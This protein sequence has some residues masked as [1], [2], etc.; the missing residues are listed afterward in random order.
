MDPTRFIESIDRQL[1]RRKVEL[2]NL[3]IMV[4]EQN[5]D[6]HRLSCIA[7]SA[8]VLAYAHWE[9]FVKRG[10]GDYVKFINGAGI[11]VADLKFP[12]QAAYVLS[13]FKRASNS[14]KTRYLG[15]L[16]QEID[17]RRAEVFSVPPDKCI[18]TESNLSSNV[19]K[20][21]V[22]GV[23]LDILPLYETRSVFIDQRIVLARNQVAHGELVSFDAVDVKDRIDGVRLLID[24]YADQLKN[25]AS[26]DA[27][28]KI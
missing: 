22:Q 20:E 23:G 6:P 14:V 19:F 17:A 27:Y 9:G 5:P 4:S 25:A 12:F 26:A 16:L 1:A 10:S 15:E 2:S 18:D 24:T 21:I 3:S 28:L 7:R 13:T 11:K 8:V